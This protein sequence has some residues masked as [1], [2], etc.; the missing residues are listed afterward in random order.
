MSLRAPAAATSTNRMSAV[1]MRRASAID[2]KEDERRFAQ[3][4]PRSLPAYLISDRLTAAVPAI[5]RDLSST[6]AKIEL[7]LGR[8]T[9]VSSAEGL[10]AKMTL[11]MVTDEMEVDISMAWREGNFIGVRFTS[12]SRAR[13]R[14]KIARRKAK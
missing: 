8:D 12:L 10:P 2:A 11:Y 3:R 7:V 1:Q 9:V 14:Q 13:A 4:K 5:V 6:G